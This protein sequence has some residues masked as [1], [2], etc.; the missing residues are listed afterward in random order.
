MSD[1]LSWPVGVCKTGAQTRAE[2]ADK[3]GV[4]V[5]GCVN[6]NVQRSRSSKA[7]L[8]CN[9][10]SMTTDKAVIGDRLPSIELRGRQQRLLTR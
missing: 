10:R 3:L 6:L 8:M 7:K 9:T 4:I 2:I 1:K 5:S